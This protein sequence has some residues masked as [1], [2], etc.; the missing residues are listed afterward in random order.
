M[1]L[2]I[3]FQNINSLVELSLGKTKPKIKNNIIIKSNMKKVRNSKSKM[4][5]KVQ[6]KDTAE[7]KNLSNISSIRSEGSAMNKNNESKDDY[8]QFLGHLTQRNRS[9]VNIES[10]SALLSKQSVITSLK[11]QKGKV[12]K[13]KKQKKHLEGGKSSFLPIITSR[14]KSNLKE[15]KTRKRKYVFRFNHKEEADPKI[16]AYNLPETKY[17]IDTIKDKRIQY[18]IVHNE[19][20][21]LLEKVKL[22]TVFSDSLILLHFPKMTLRNQRSF[23]TKFEKL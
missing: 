22:M 14:I 17:D 6:T 13:P 7:E 2:R 8:A 19:M 1:N 10:S 9:I 4:K 21:C 3:N 20:N 11:I 15:G 16:K 23:N 18:T 12:K 5:L